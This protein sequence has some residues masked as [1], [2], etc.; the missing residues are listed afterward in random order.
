MVSVIREKIHLFIRSISITSD[1]KQFSSG[2]MLTAKYSYLTAVDK[3][4]I[5][6]RETCILLKN[7]TSRLTGSFTQSNPNMHS[8]K[9]FQIYFAI[10]QNI[11]TDDPL[12]I[13]KKGRE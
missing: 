8:Q 10:S 13:R 3:Y 7:I 11:L 12:K 2:K 5:F 1:R 9:Y 4:I 6:S